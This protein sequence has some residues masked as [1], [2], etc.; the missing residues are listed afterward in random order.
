[1]LHRARFCYNKSSVRPSV[2]PS[3]CLSVPPF[4]CDVEVSWSH[5]LECFKNNLTA[6]FSLQTPASRI[7]SKTNTRNFGRKGALYRA[8]AIWSFT[9][10]SALKLCIYAVQNNMPVLCRPYLWCTTWKQA[11]LKRLQIYKFSGR[12]ISEGISPPNCLPRLDIDVNKLETG[13]EFNR[14]VADLSLRSG[15]GDNSL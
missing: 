4:V 1:M 14:I 11:K 3:V 5:R 10:R 2:R 12:G 9:F 7:Y 15:S 8:V 6:F 13:F